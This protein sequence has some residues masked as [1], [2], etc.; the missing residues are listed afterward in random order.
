GSIF[1][2]VGETPTG[3]HD[4]DFSGSDDAMSPGIVTMFQRTFEGNG[5]NLHVVMWMLAET[6][7]SFYVVVIQ[8]AEHSKMY[9][10]GIV[11]TR[12]TEGMIGIEPTVIG[13]T[14]GIGFV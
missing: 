7:A 13:V 9:P 10:V 5:N 4:L 3:A 11:I 12:E 6:H 14:P 8:Y 1:F 2:T